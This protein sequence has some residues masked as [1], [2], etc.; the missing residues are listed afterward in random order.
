MGILE[1]RESKCEY[2]GLGDGK[3]GGGQKMRMEM[4]MIEKSH[5]VKS[6]RKI[7]R[8]NQEKCQR[9]RNFSFSAFLPLYLTV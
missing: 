7:S 3:G 9:R 2:V 1:S 6:G 8:V 4:L 5:R